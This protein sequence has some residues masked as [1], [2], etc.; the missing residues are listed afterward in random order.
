M[1]WN[2]AAAASAWWRARVMWGLDKLAAELSKKLAHPREQRA[3]HVQVLSV[4][5]LAEA[6]SNSHSAEI[7]TG[8]GLERPN[9]SRR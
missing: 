8:A 5:G 9:S 1:C 7:I 4:F 6:I 3:S 2:S